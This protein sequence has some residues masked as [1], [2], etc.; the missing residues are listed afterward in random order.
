MTMA[1]P[2]DDELLRAMAGGDGAA[3]AAF[4]RR[5]LPTVLAYLLRETGDREVAADLAAEV[6][7]AVLLSAGR[8]RAPAAGSD[9]ARASALPWVLGIARNK[10]AMSRRRGRVEAQ[11]RLRLGLEPVAFEDADLEAVDSLAGSAS[12]LLESLPALERESVRARVLD[13]RSYASI[14]A[15]LQCSE[16][17]VRKRVSRG[18]QRMRERLEEGR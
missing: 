5:H 4:Y 11:A 12:A 9:A 6:F 8:Y 2:G 3:T 13:D 14:A 16:M 18:L 7:A 1:H 17:V 15:E 10:L